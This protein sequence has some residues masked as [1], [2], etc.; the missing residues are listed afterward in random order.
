MFYAMVKFSTPAGGTLTILADNEAHAKKLLT[1][2]HTSV[3]DFEIVDIHDLDSSPQ[4][5]AMIEAA[6]E[7][8][9]EPTPEKETLN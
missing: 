3:K 4:I 2:M 8:Q 7:A 1:E 9:D 5:K 6:A